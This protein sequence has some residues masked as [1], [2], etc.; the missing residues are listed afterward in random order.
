MLEMKE[1]MDLFEKRNCNVDVLVF[2]RKALLE[3]DRDQ[4]RLKGQNKLLFLLK[5]ESEE[6]APL[7]LSALA[8]SYFW[9]KDYQNVLYY[10]KRVIALYPLSPFAL[11]NLSML[12]CVFRMLGMRRECF[13]AQ[14]QKMHTIKKIVVQTQ[15][16]EERIY[17]L[18]ELMK[19]Y[20]S[21]DCMEEASR[22]YE[23]LKNLLHHN[24]AKQNYI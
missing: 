6:F 16:M 13:E 3:I 9:S 14:G 1:L 10:C 11:W 22:C 23:E 2:I 8:A 15:D 12:V 24:A 19:E 7:V 4:T 5:K 21:R 20:E 18:N 17:A